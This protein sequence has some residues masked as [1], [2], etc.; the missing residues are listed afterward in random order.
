L[1]NEPDGRTPDSKQGQWIKARIAASKSPWQV[2]VFHHP[3][4]SSG[5]H[6]SMTPMRWPFEAWGVDAVLTGHEHSYERILRDD[7][8]NGVKLPYF[9]TGL[10]GRLPRAITRSV[11]G[12]MSRYW[13]DYG[14]LFVT[15]SATALSFE[16]RN[17]KGL[18]IDTYSVKKGA[19][20]STTEFEFRIPPE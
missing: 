11:A 6:G 17:T 20:Q 16:F 19:T 8:A 3:P 9:I 15:A 1:T 7:N 14:A 13:A 12:S 4:F 2:V 18:V 5:Y 10:G